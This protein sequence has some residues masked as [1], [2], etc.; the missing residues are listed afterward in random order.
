MA[1]NCVHCA[2]EKKERELEYQKALAEGRVVCRCGIC[3][4]F[5]LKDSA[6]YIVKNKN[7]VNSNV[8]DTRVC[9]R[10][11]EIYAFKCNEDG[12]CG[13]Y[14]SFP[15][16]FYK[17]VGEKKYCETC[18]KKNYFHCGRCSQPF[19]K[20][21][22]NEYRGTICC[23]SCKEYMINETVIRSSIRDYSYKPEWEFHGKR[24]DIKYGVEL[25][26]STRDVNC[27]NVLKALQSFN[28]SNP[29]V[30]LKRDGSIVNGG[31]EIVSHPHS[32]E[33]HKEL[34]EP[35]F[36]LDFKSLG[37]SG[38]Q[39]GMHV[40][41]SRSH[42]DK[43]TIGKMIVFVNKS[44]NKSLINKIA[45]RSSQQWAKLDPA[46]SDVNNTYD[47]DRYVAINTLNSKTIEFRIFK[48]T[49]KKSSFFKNLEFIEALVKWAKVTEPEN[50]TQE[51]YLAYVVN[52]K[53]NY[54]NLYKYLVSQR[55]ITTDNKVS[56]VVEIRPPVTKKI[57]LT[58]DEY[59]IQ[60]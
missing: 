16:F 40:H 54:E 24:A 23:A 55:F 9:K 39:N 42:L 20:S 11:F 6:E 10:C 43:L 35:F 49:T 3:S 41:V 8:E 7:G 58:I 38:D 14:F 12:G 15:S 30:I 50:L 48:G 59:D 44:G 19:P 60:F 53:D 37:I 17:T 29:R 57:K 2:T 22:E 47:P 25:E 27:L 4:S 21:L 26:L 1:C 56:A 34:W 5:I 46:K 28:V 32:L 51:L 31:F 52:N 36:D 18:F 13:N 33:A 45:E